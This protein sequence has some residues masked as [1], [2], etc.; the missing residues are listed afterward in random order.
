LGLHFL[1]GLLLGIVFVWALPILPP[2]LPSWVIGPGYGAVLFAITLAIGKLVL[3]AMPWSR[4]F[5]SAAVPVAFVT[6][7]AY[8]L[9]LALVIM[10]S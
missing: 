3:G 6:H 1:H 4:E 7:L 5:G 10:W 8:G 9:V 2:G